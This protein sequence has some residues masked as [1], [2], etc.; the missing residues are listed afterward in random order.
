MSTFHKR[1]SLLAF[2]YVKNMYIG[3]I[4]VPL[5]ELIQLFYDDS[6]WMCWVL[7]DTQLNQLKHARDKEIICSQLII[8]KEIQFEI[9]LYPNGTFC[10]STEDCVVFGLRMKYLPPNIEYYEF[11]RE[12][13]CE[14]ANYST[15]GLFEVF[16][17]NFAD[18]RTICKL[19]ELKNANN[20]HFSCMIYFKR[21]K[22]KKH[23]NKIDYYSPINKIQR[24]SR[25][26][27]NCDDTWLHKSKAARMISTNTFNN[28]SFC[29]DLRFDPYGDLHIYFRCLYVP[30]FIKSMSIEL[31]CNIGNRKGS[32]YTTRFRRNNQL[33]VLSN[34]SSTITLYRRQSLS[35]SVSVKIKYIYD[36]NNE[37]I[38]E[39]K[40][41]KFGIIINDMKERG[42]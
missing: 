31:K 3:A 27:W 23:C 13:N 37:K 9:L 26:E 5:I 7:N 17:K 18:T 22:Y 16:G 33:A 8:I 10:R 28:N 35:I 32:K 15:K 14:T 21:I 38:G 11:Y 40:W 42:E 19:S 2:G 24:Y 4:P 30:H 25:Y 29:L 6:T 20:L 39:N 12:I 41:E 1:E 36:G 34:T